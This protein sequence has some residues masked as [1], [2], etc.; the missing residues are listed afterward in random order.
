MGAPMRYG[1]HDPFQGVDSTYSTA[2]HGAEG[3]LD[4]TPTVRFNNNNGFEDVRLNDRTRTSPVREGLGSRFLSSLSNAQ[5]TAAAI[6]RSGSIL[7]GRARSWAAYVPKLNTNSTS[8]PEKQESQPKPRPQS[9]IFGDLF[10]GES[11]PVQLGVPT[12]PTKEKEETEF[13]M[14]YQPG[15][16]T[17]RPIGGRVRKDSA[18][19]TPTP[20]PMNAGNRKTSWFTRKPTLPAPA[21]AAVKAVE[22]DMLNLNINAGLFPH[23]PA[24]PL[25]PH[26]FND[27]LLNATN[28]LQRMQAAYKEK[29]D[30][31][32]SIQPEIDAQKEEVDEAR[33]RSEHL[34]MQLEDIGRKAEEQRQVNEELLIQLSREKVKVQE[35]QE[36]AKTI[37]LVRRD[38]AETGFDTDSDEMH[39][40]RKRNSGGNASDS[41]FESDADTSSVF[42]SHIDTPVSAQYQQQPRLVVTL[43]HQSQPQV[44]YASSRDSR[45]SQQSTAYSATKHN[46]SAFTAW[47]TVERLRNENRDL[48]TQM[49]EMQCNLQSCIDLVSGATRP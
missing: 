31:I 45:M 34:K 35:A 49:E 44:R 19:K 47:T 43:D 22:D 10:N 11:A 39:R 48:R 12:S 24:D 25:S 29:V 4:L 23:G 21:P 33:T 3:N 8:S 14:E 36:Q 2:Y 42:S 38:T 9:K 17:E 13:V 46:D 30:Y 20:T 37:R 5:P 40:R 7:H 26:A 28:L 15:N 16:F 41:G 6:Q 18:S 27:L 32:A 1:H